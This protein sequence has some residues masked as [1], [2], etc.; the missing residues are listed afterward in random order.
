MVLREHTNASGNPKGLKL[1][2]QLPTCPVYIPYSYSRRFL[3]DI[4]EKKDE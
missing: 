2:L 1:G 4:I 3:G